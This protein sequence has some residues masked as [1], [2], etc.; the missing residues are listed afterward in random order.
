M[1]SKLEAQYSQE[2]DTMKRQD[3][4]EVLLQFKDCFRTEV[5]CQWLDRQSTERL[6]ILVLA[7]RLYRVL[8]Q[9]PPV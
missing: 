1:N 9:Q 8:R 2:I 3:L 4:I 6:R 7:A 5:T